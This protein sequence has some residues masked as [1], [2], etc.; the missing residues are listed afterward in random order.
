M[1]RMLVKIGGIVMAASVVLFIIVFGVTY[2][3]AEA[4]GLVIV[5]IILAPFIAPLVMLVWYLYQF[6]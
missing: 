5:L 3:W 6:L 4:G 2:G 1:V